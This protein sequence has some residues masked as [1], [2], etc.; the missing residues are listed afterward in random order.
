[1]KFEGYVVL[2]AEALE[3]KGIK[4]DGNNPNIAYLYSTKELA[5]DFLAGLLKQI[6]REQG[7][8]WRSH[9][10]L[11]KKKGL[12]FIIQKCTIEIS[13]A[14]MEKRGWKI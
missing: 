14:S 8:G 9:D 6:K 12:D 4:G 1:M 3:F 11:D 10:N 7:I 5:T 13:T 2:Q